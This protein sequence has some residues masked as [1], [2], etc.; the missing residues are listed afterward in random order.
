M[1]DA[2]ILVLVIKRSIN[3]DDTAV[4]NMGSAIWKPFVESE[5]N[6][7]VGAN[8]LV[9]V[10]VLAFNWHDYN[11]LGYI[12]SVL[13][14]IYDALSTESLSYLAWKKIEKFTGS[15]PF[16]RSWDNC[17]KVLIG[18]KDY[19]KRMNLRDDEMVNFTT[20]KKLNEELLDLWKRG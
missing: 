20:N 13:P 14:F 16:W 4:V 1:V 8:E 7:Q 12:K 6:S 17:R 5:L 18:V 19:C 10:Y 11:A 2:L 3:P 9:Y 15:V